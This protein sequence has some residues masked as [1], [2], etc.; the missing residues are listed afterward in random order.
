MEM[1]PDLMMD[2]AKGIG[3]VKKE[4]NYAY[5]VETSKIE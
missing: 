1:K 5:I 3:K 4:N 2:S